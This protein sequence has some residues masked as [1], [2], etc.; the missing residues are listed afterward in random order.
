MSLVWAANEISD[1]DLHFVRDQ[2]IKALVQEHRGY[3]L[4]EILAWGWGEADLRWTRNG[5]LRLRSDYSAFFQGILPPSEQHP[6]LVGITRE[7]VEAG[8]GSTIST[9]FVYTPPRFFFKPNEQAV[10]RLALEP[11]TDDEIAAALYIGRHAV[12]KR[13][14]S[15]FGRVK[16]A[17]PEFFP[18]VKNSADT[19]PRASQSV[20]NGRKNSTD[21]KAE[22]SVQKRWALLRYLRHHPEELCPVEPF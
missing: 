3:L 17:D 8:E 5:G 19:D 16:D 9:L 18:P 11:R 1:E 15:I 14:E 13:W 4:N 21:P 22:K 20:R 2:A 10:L 7:E 6:F 12:R